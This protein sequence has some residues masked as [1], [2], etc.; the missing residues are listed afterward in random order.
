MEPL[1]KSNFFNLGFSLLNVGWFY[2]QLDYRLQSFWTY[3]YNIV[4][5]NKH[6]KLEWIPLNSYF[7]CKLY[8]LKKLLYLCILHL[9]IIAIPCSIVDI[10]YHNL[11]TKEKAST[12]RNINNR[13]PNV[14]N[15]KTIFTRRSIQTFTFDR[16]SLSH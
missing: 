15:F 6:F 7:F 4:P 2:L 16:W 9:Y 3:R 11:Q 12:K 13:F 1:P 10:K 14:C 8:Y 5:T